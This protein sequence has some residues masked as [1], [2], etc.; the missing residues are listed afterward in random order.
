MGYDNYWVNLIEINEIIDKLNALYKPLFSKKWNLDYQLEND[1]INIK[2]NFFRNN[3]NYIKYEGNI[4]V[5]FTIGMMSNQY[6]NDYCV[7][8]KLTI[9][10]IF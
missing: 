8:K 4:I 5:K 1:V 7:L 3:K 9:E 6:S 10:R 2:N